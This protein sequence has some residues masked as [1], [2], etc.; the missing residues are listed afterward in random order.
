MKVFISTVVTRN[1]SI[2]THETNETNKTNESNKTNET[3]E[4]LVLSQRTNYELIRCSQAVV[5]C[6]TRGLVLLGGGDITI[7]ARF[8]ILVRGY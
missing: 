6:G 7:V 3:N 4:R 8:T 2:A 1:E 5:T